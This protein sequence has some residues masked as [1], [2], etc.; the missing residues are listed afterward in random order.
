MYLAVLALTRSFDPK[1]CPLSFAKR[2]WEGDGD[3]VV[4]KS[5]R[6]VS[7]SDEATQGYVSD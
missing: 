1:L 6:H 5:N 2:G 7:F 4:I 3:R